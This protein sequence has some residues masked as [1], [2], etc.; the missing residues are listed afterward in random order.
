MVLE[1]VV[2]G[3]PKVSEAAMK[4]RWKHNTMAWI[5]HGIPC[6]E[7][8]WFWNFWYKINPHVERSKYHET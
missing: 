4:L 7:P 3:E 8:K 6:K 1:A 2:L 5:C